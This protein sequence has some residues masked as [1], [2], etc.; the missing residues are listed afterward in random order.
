MYD[1][2]SRKLKTQ[3]KVSRR[4]DAS[5]SGKTKKTSQEA[6]SM[7]V[8]TAD[9]AGCGLRG[10]TWAVPVSVPVV[11]HHWAARFSVLVLLSR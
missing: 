1:S 2:I 10:F 8:R 9:T 6:I 3:A 7:K 4:R 5:L 11:L